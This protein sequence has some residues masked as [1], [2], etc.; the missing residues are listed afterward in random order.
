MSDRCDF[1]SKIQLYNVM[2][3]STMMSVHGEP[4]GELIS[5]AR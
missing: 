1:S 4:A 5:S 3:K 2:L